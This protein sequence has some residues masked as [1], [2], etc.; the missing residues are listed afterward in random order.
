MNIKKNFAIKTALQHPLKMSAP[1]KK[2]NILLV[3]CTRIATLKIFISLVINLKYMNCIGMV[4]IRLMV[5]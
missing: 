3:Q 2:K 5:N 4:Y 1:R